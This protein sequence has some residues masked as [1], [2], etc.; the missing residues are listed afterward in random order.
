MACPI[1]I[2]IRRVVGKSPQKGRSPQFS[3]HLYCCQTVAWI[4]ML[5]GTEVGLG[6]RDVAA[7]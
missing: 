7:V 4:K 2:K 1:P 5:L 3:T 6:L